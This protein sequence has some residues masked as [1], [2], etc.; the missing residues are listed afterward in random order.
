MSDAIWP[1]IAVVGLMVGTLLLP[2]K[3]DPAMRIKLWM[4][5]R[6]WDTW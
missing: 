6:G 4:I 2:A 3:W 1:L 5:S